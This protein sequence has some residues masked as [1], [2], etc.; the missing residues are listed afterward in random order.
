MLIV[1][2]KLSIFVRSPPA[3]IYKNSHLYV[4]VM[5]TYVWK[6]IVAESLYDF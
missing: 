6:I 4:I 5:N 2:L 1:N 3:V